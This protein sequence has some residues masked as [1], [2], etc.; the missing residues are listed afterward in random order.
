MEK[1]KSVKPSSNFDVLTS[2][3]DEMLQHPIEPKYVPYPLRVSGKV[4]K[5][6]STGI[7][8]SPGNVI[9]ELVSNSFDAD[10]KHVYVLTGKPSFD[11]FYMYDDGEGM[12]AS[13]FT[14]TMQRIGAS[15]KIPG[16]FTKKRRPIIGRIGIGLLAVGHVSKRFT[17]VSLT[18]T[19]L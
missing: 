10:A 3:V 18:L 4:V 13:E 6:I 2:Q 7:Y 5:Q 12:S 17:F 9:K 8:R 14:T 1:C 15:V 19:K 11:S 16:E